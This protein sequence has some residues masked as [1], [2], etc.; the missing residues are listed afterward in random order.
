MRRRGLLMIAC[1]L[2]LCFGCQKDKSEDKTVKK[3][4]SEEKVEKNNYS[5]II[6]DNEIDTENEYP[7][8][9]RV[10]RAANCITVYGADDTGKYILPTRA[11]ICSTGGE[12]T[13]LGTF[14]LGE[15]S[16]WL[17]EDDGQFCQYATSIVNDITFRSVSYYTQNNHNIDVEQFNMLGENVSGSSIHLET[18]D[19]KWI[20]NNCPQGTKVEI[21]EDSEEAGPIGKPEARILEED[22][23]QDPTDTGKHTQKAGDYIPVEFDGIEDATIQ[24]A[25]KFDLLE[26]VTAQ[27]S[28]KEDLTSQIQV[29]GTVNTETPGNYE[30]TYLCKNEDG[31]LR[32]AKR[33]IQVEAIQEV[34][35]TEVPTETV[36]TPSTTAPQV[37]QNTQTAS[38]NLPALKTPEPTVEPTRT[39]EPT[40]EPTRTPETVFYADTESPDI[41]IIADTILTK[42]VERATLEKRVRVTDNSGSIRDLYITVCPLSEE[43]YY[44]VIYEAVDEAGNA[45]C[46]SE[47]V[48]LMGSVVFN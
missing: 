19:A 36:M 2:V 8:V 22:A 33:M 39:P 23:V 30:L 21:Y 48:E 35:P 24:V 12:E 3:S 29:Y 18:A 37:T 31:E 4:A 44:A 5:P 1:A 27:N 45:V 28:E 14:Q 25:Q 46:I 7:Y 16:R 20:A 6:S 38:V 40:V 10:N 32:I 47:T 34:Q 42:D 15:T 9:I 17:M 43:P 41:E 13:P 11:M 26:G